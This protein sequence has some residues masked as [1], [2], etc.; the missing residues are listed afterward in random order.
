MEPFRPEKQ[1]FRAAKAAKL[2]IRPVT[3]NER[4]RKVSFV[5]SSRGKSYSIMV[6]PKRPRRPKN[7]AEIELR[8]SAKKRGW[9][10]GSAD[11]I[12][13]EMEHGFFLVG[14]KN[15]LRL[16]K[17]QVNSHVRSKTMKD[18]S[19]LVYHLPNTKSKLT[20]IPYEDLKRLS[21]RIL[22]KV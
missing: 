5:V 3:L 22:Q 4:R 17:M 11:I 8:S 15:L 1:F 7:L 20:F 10:Y 13:F 9:I 21:F 16:C 14:R 2:A 19:Y 6:I 12:A 18:A